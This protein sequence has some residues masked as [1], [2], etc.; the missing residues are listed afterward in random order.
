MRKIIALF[1]VLAMSL[2]IL[3]MPAAY[4]DTNFL[5]ARAQRAFMGQRS[6]GTFIYG[7]VRNSTIP[8][9]QAI[10]TEYQ[11]QGASPSCSPRSFTMASILPSSLNACVFREYL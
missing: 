6:D 10:C 11:V 2:V 8:G 5:N 3:P 4:A 9:L 7:M 1:T